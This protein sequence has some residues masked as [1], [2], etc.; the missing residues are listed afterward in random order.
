MSV[1]PFSPCMR[2]TLSHPGAN[3]ALGF[4]HEAHEAPTR[5]VAAPSA[6]PK[7]RAPWT[8]PGKR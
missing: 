1:C 5:L 8:T 4:N 6:L 7:G 3:T 2:T